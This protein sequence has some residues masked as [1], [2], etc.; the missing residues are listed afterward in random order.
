MKL[1]NKVAIVT[2]GSAGIGAATVKSY[3]EPGA[4]VYSLDLYIPQ[5]VVE[6]VSSEV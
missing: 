5:D 1:K 2:G 4:K 6:N 3:V